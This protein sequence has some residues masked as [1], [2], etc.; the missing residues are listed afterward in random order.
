MLCYLLPRLHSSL[1]Q[2]IIYDSDTEDVVKLSEPYYLTDINKMIKDD[3]EWNYFKKITYSYEYLNS[4]D[5]KPSSQSYFKILEL[6]NKFYIGD[7]GIGK[8]SSIE[9]FHMINNDIGIVEGFLKKRNNDD[10]KHTV[11]IGSQLNDNDTSLSSQ[12]QHLCI[13]E[14]KNIFFFQ[15][16][17]DF[18]TSKNLKDINKKHKSSKD[19]ITVDIKTTD[20]KILFEKICYALCIQKQCGNLIIKVKDINS[21]FSIDIFGLLSSLYDQVFITKP[22]SSENYDPEKFIVCN[23]FIPINFD[24]IFNVLLKFFENLETLIY[25]NSVVT[26][27]KDRNIINRYFMNK[28]EE[29]SVIFGQHYIEN[30]H[31]TLNLIN[32]C[33]DSKHCPEKS[34]IPFIIKSNIKK[35][36]QWHEVNTLS[37]P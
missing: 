32:V 17:F 1:Y 9:T 14:K 5:Y 3:A 7:N 8:S 30:I 12:L 13:E 37:V 10:D 29:Y 2:S 6:F 35:C 20:I 34:K 21:N 27:F 19:F 23:D 24:Q 22:L 18:F 31:S 28:I 33:N 11:M 15:Q 36:L 16:S 25:T 4:N 26:L